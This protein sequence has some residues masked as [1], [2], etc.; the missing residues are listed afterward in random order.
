M[1]YEVITDA[2]KEYRDQTTYRRLQKIKRQMRPEA[3]MCH[4]LLYD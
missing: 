2:V 1:L 3:V 4:V